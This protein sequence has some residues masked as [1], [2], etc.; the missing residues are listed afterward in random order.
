M[1]L[2]AFLPNPLLSDGG[3]D[4]TGHVDIAF[5]VDRY[6]RSRHVRVLDTSNDAR[7]AEKRLVQLISR[8]RFRP[9]L[10]RGGVAD[11]GPIVV[12]YDFNAFDGAQSGWSLYWA[13]TEA[14]ERGELA[15]RRS[16][17]E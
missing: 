2:P 3:C 16:P 13:P 11:T 1:I 7:L 15:V 10:S 9:R 5:E 17:D 12:R 6:G 4:Y 14:F 8:A